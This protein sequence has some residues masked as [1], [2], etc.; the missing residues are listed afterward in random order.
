M[1]AISRSRK[2]SHGERREGH[3]STQ[4][5]ILTL[6]TSIQTI[7]NYNISIDLRTFSKPPTLI[8]S[9]PSPK[10]QKHFLEDGFVVR[11][12]KK[13]RGKAGAVGPGRRK[14]TL[15]ALKTCALCNEKSLTHENNLVHWKEKHPDD[16]V[17]GVEIWHNFITD[18]CIPGLTIIWEGA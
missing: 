17:G 13:E 11:K 10:V 7:G 8:F 14:K 15:A 3:P 12:V 2:T 9:A 18:M 5:M 16:E 6:T 4:D 1:T